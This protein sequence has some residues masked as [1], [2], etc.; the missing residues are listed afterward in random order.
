MM[1]VIC[2]KI[3]LPVDALENPI[4]PLG[5]H[6]ICNPHSCNYVLLLDDGNFCLMGQSQQTVKYP[7]SSPDHR[8]S[9]RHEVCHVLTRLHCIPNLTLSS[10]MQ[11]F[12]N[13]FLQNALLHKT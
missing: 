5:T 7:L 4:L 8:I 3:R 10:V 13:V 9:T 2:K 11:C 6:V 12:I 1:M